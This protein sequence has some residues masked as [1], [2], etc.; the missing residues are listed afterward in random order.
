MP[1]A[2]HEKV[3]PATLSARKQAGRKFPVLTCYDYPTARIMVE[4]GV[5]VLLVGDTV[6]EVVLGYPETRSVSMDFMI[7][8]ASAVRRGA[9]SG[10]VIGDMPYSAGYREDPAAGLAA[11]RRFRDEAGCDIVKIEMNRDY[12]RVLEQVRNAGIDVMAHIGLRPQWLAEHGGY[13]AQG[14]DADSAMELLEEARLMEEAGAS[15]LLLEAVAAEVSAEI[16]ARR[17]FP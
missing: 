13:K 15:M 10:L 3:T 11:A 2:I 17:S 14:K 8:V 9:P 16:C 6:A 4:A 7:E 12:L 5:D 1:N